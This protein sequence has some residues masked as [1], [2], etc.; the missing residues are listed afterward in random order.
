MARLTK[1]QKTFIDEYMIDFNA[2]QAAIRAGYSPESAKEIGSENLT[3]PN[4]SNEID[5]RIAERS[6]R[7]GITAERVLIEYARIAFLNPADV[8]DF[9]SAT[10][11]PDASVDDLAAVSGVKIKRIS[12]GDGDIEEREIKLCNKQQALDALAKHL[13]L[14][15]ININMQGDEEQKKTINAIAS[16]LEQMKPIEDDEIVGGEDD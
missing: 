11:K 7:T 9:E 8:I 3:K 12:N 2:A 4:I 14:N 13:G 10:I 6:R 5:R 15:R 16:I 1:K